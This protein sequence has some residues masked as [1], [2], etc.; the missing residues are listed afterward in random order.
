MLRPRGRL[1]PGDVFAAVDVGA[2]KAACLIASAVSADAGP[3]YEILGVGL[4]G[5]APQSRSQTAQRGV[6]TLL[7]GAVE[8]AER[9]AGLRIKSASVAVAG[10]LL[11]TR[12]GG[13]DLDLGGAR[14]TREDVA[15]CLSHAAAAATPDS[16]ALLHA[17]PSRFSVDGVEAGPH[18]EGLA[19]DMLTVEAVA[20]SARES[21]LHNIE[22]LLERC[23]IALDRLI[24]GPYAAAEAA[25]VDDEKDLGVVVLDIGA[26]STGY[27][28]YEDGRLVD[29]GGV[30]VGGDHIT[31]DIAQLFTAPLAQ[32]ERMKTLYG[33]A[34]AGPGDEHR[35]VEFSLLGD[36]GVTRVSRADLAAVILP[37]MEEICELAAA[38][39]PATARARHGVRRAVLTGGASLLVGARE[40]VER[41]LGMKARLGR[42]TTVSGAPDAASAPTF[43]VC[44]GAL[45]LAYRARQGA[46]SEISPAET[47]Q[48]APS[49]GLAASVGHWLKV[50]F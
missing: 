28:A 46:H 48:R 41:I 6:E 8:S 19:G 38:R 4:H 23:G 2:S 21:A 5:A 39:L 34:I 16:Y 31:R 44:A 26:S 50:N 20:M 14:V 18:P 11:S 3:G 37:R 49:T 27:A 47:P 25:L 10:R 33:S 13:V 45:L 42:A 1:R 7:R 12:R 17:I 15:S 24:A 32:A 22:S 36:S 43:S 29:C 30:P 9:M 35:V 40:T